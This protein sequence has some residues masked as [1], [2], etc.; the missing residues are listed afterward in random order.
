MALVIPELPRPAIIA[1]EEILPMSALATLHPVSGK[2][3][4]FLAGSLTLTAALPNIPSNVEYVFAEDGGS[5]IAS[6]T[7]I[8]NIPKSSARVAIKNVRLDTSAT[9]IN[10]E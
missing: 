1:G 3:Y 8:F 5:V 6:T 7:R 4:R 2:R 10:C 9:A